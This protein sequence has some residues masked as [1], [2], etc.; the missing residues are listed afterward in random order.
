MP[1]VPRPDNHKLASQLKLAVDNEGFF[2]EAHVKLGPLEFPADGISLCGCAKAPMMLKESCEAGSGA[3]VRVL[4]GREVLG[5]FFCFS[6]AT[7]A[8]RL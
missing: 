5:D 6:S 7:A 8:L 4:P 1:V 2:Q 3:A